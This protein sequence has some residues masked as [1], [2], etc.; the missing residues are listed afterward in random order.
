MPEPVVIN[1]GAGESSS[2]GL[3]LLFGA[4]AFGLVIFFLIYFAA[5]ILRNASA[6]SVPSI[7]VP[8]QIDVNVNPNQ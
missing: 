2:N 7:N 4:I 3:G 6:P 1:S 5:P 8:E